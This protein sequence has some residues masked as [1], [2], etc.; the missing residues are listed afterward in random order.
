M[1]QSTYLWLVNMN[2]TGLFTSWDCCSGEVVA[3]AAVVNYRK[4]ATMKPMLWDRLARRG[5]SSDK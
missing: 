1:M 4:Q 5:K 2:K 3:W